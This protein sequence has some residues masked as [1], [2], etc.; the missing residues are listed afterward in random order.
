[1]RSMVKGY[2]RLAFKLIQDLAEDVTFTNNGTSDFDYSTGEAA[3]STP[4]SYVFR[5]V[6][7][8]ET[9]KGT[10]TSV[11]KLLFM[12][13]QFDLAGIASID[14]FDQVTVRGN[15]LKVI[16]PK[17]ISSQNSDNGY[18]MTIYAAQEDV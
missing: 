18:T 6:V 7:L 1:M 14:V 17:E 12:T 15:V 13:E 16:H 8:K 4:Q 10:N 9:L 11:I 3:P 2:V 5:A